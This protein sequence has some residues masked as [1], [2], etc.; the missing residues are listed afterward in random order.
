MVDF[1]FN[2]HKGTPKSQLSGLGGTYY[3]AQV[4][5]TYNENPNLPH[6]GIMFRRIGGGV[7]TTSDYAIPLFQ[8]MQTVPLLDEH[9]I[10]ISGPGEAA[11]LKQS[12]Y[13][14]P[15][16]IWN[17]PLHGGR[18]PGD[19]APKLSNE[20][21][22]TLDINPM[23][24]FPG[25]ILHEGR[26]GQSI[27]FSEGNTSGRAPWKTDTNHSPVI[28]IANGQIKTT[29]GTYP[30]VEDINQ[31]PASIY[32]TSQNQLPLE[33]SLKWARIDNSKRY[34]SYLPGNEPLEASTYLGNQV[35]LNSGRIYINSNKEHV[36]ISAADTVGMLGQKVNLDA[37]KTITLEA[38][39]INFTGDALNPITA[40]SAVKGEDLVDEL[41]GLY[42]RLADLTTT[43]QIVLSTLNVPTDSAA[44]LTT[45]LIKGGDVTNLSAD[46]IKSKLKELLSNRVKLS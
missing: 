38:P 34:S 42:K 40:R 37:A 31:D 27:R 22:E 44:K 39:L 11:G 36:L 2:Q 18:G 8:H 19:I 29:E 16:N 24:V 21:K 30:V 5:E 15:I 10:I 25:D 28:V 23:L 35:I 17:H 33:V 45:Y 13:L 6:A 3:T 1:G 43:L 7:N 32:L 14:P 12:Y 4:I 9:V 41:A 20:F 26:R 46:G